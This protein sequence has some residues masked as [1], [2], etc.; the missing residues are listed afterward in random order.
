MDGNKTGGLS[1][2]RRRNRTHIR[3][4][5]Y[6]RAPITRTEIAHE[7]GLTLP[8]VTTSV[9][10]MLEDGLLTETLMAEPAGSAG[11]RPPLL[12]GFN[13]EAGRALGVELG[14]Y[15]TAV[16][17]TDLV[18]NPVAQTLL[19]AVQ[20]YDEMLEQ[21]ETAL[22]PYLNEDKLMGVGLGLPG[23]V[24]RESGEVRTSILGRK[25]DNR[26]IA[27]DLSQ[28]LGVPVMVDNNVR[29]RAGGQALFHGK[30]TENLFAYLFVSKGI[31][32]PLM[33]RG[34][35]LSGSTSGAGELGHMVMQPGG[36][37]CP[38]CGR[39]GCL[40]SLTG[41]TAILRDCTEQ[42][43]AGRARTLAAICGDQPPDI[44]AVL[45]AQQAGDPDI[46]EVM[47]DALR[48]LGLALANVVNL[49]SPAQVLVEGYLFRYESNKELLL[50]Y[51]R[52]HFYSLNEQQV[53]IR[54]LEFNRYGGALGAAAAVIEHFCIQGE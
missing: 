50:K 1:E 33:I 2:V 32:C 45:Q 38:T 11:G 41:E 20:E 22:R 23:F 16:V 7:L 36:R 54:F 14:P 6:R 4:I 12:L 37:I 3:E 29:M 42:L 34:R 30:E 47:E 18:G 15:E 49:I 26:P 25:W 5:I 21:L 53:Q 51:A 52:S 13:P 46:A 35:V 17:L 24:S 27:G 48:Y 39:R 9:A 10:Q 28:R 44:R 43:Q 40:E 8:T 31:A 19:P